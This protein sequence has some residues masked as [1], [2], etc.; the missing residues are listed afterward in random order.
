MTLIGMAYADSVLS[1]VIGVDT[2]STELGIERDSGD[3]QGV[4]RSLD[5]ALADIEGSEVG[6]LLD[7]CEWKDG[8]GL[9]DGQVG[10]LRL[11]GWSCEGGV[12][13]IELS[14]FGGEVA[15]FTFDDVGELPHVARPIVLDQRVLD[16]VR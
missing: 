13:T 4:R 1:T 12:Q 11:D 5:I 15:H 8:P 9:I 10:R 2:P 3:A 14:G 6:A 7:L 16:A